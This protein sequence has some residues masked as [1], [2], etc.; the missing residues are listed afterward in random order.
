MIQHRTIEANDSEPTTQRQIAKHLSLH[1]QAVF[2]DFLRCLFPPPPSGFLAGRCIKKA[3]DG[4]DPQGGLRGDAI[5][6]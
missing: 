5:E 2:W 6:H 1:S 4:V 3:R